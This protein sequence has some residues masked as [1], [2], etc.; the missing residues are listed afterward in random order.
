M[1]LHYKMNCLP[2]PAV[3]TLA[4]KGKITKRLA[5]L[6]KWL[7]ICMSCICGTAHCKPR[8]HKGSHG[9]IQKETN[10]APGKCVSMDQLVSAQLGLIPQLAGFL[11]NLRNWVELYLLTTF[12][13]TFLLL[14]CKTSLL[15]KHSLPSHL[16]KDML[17]KEV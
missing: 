12:Q 6:K 11:T 15:M 17:R 4:E 10:N 9:A 3:I 1:N 8:Q 7:P 16:S 5:K 13:I 2:L 14:L